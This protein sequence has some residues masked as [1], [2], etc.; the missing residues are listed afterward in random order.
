MP[1]P[2]IS[3]QPSPEQTRQPVPPHRKHETSSSTL[4]SVKGK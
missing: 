1:A 4:G 3:I 2:R